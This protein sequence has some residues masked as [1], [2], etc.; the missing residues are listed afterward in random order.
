MNIIKI[1]QLNA[2]NQVKPINSKFILATAYPMSVCNSIQSE[3]TELDQVIK[4][5]L[6][7]KNMLVQQGC[8]ERLPM[9]RRDGKKRTS[10]ID[11]SF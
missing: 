6:R 3:L 5:D 2:K 11:R 4:K 7:K 10:V 8:N 9:K 1:T